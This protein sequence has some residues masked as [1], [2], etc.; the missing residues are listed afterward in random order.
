MC[1][2]ILVVFD[3][4]L[5]E[6]QPPRG[7]EARYLGVKVDQEFRP[8]SA[9]N[10]VKPVGPIDAESEFKVEPD[11]DL[12]SAIDLQT[13]RRKSQ[14]EINRQIHQRSFLVQLEIKLDLIRCSVAVE[15][16]HCNSDIVARDLGVAIVVREQAK[17]W[18]G[19]KRFEEGILN[20]V[21][22][23]G[24]LQFRFERRQNILAKIANNCRAVREVISNQ[25]QARLEDPIIECLLQQA[26][27]RI[28]PI[29]NHPEIIQQIKQIELRMDIRGADVNCAGN[30]AE[31][32]NVDR[33]IAEQV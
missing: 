20:Q 8:C 16:S 2:I 27:Q 1:R 21:F 12:H 10:E 15:I 22:G 6:E 25:R 30:I 23:L 11:H 28:Q 7:R 14:I 9:G 32:V 33:K 4:E 26:Q 5:E 19:A 31:V 18:R 29:D 3:V 13:E 24:I 17:A